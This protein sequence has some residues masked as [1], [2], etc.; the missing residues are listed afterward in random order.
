M[1]FLVSVE[2]HFQVEIPDECLSFEFATSLNGFLAAVFSIIE[3]KIIVKDN[4]K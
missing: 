2:E 1:L 3:N 4:P